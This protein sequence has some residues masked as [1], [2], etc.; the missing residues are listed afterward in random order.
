MLTQ[1]QYQEC[2]EACLTCMEKCNTC[3]DACLDEDN[4]KM[5]AACIRLDR[6][7]AD[8]CSFTA[9][10]IQTNSPILKEVIKLCVEICQACGDECGRHN[11][12][13]CQNCADA[14]YHCAEV[15]RKIIA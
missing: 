10:A 14:C 8:I 9:R 4:V 3:F 5:M 11:H 13:H 7:C 15:C 1:S 12:E 2:L 6:E